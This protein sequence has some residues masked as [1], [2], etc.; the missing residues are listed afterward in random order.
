M[1]KILA[2]VLII[3]GLILMTRHS[4]PL[5]SFGTHS[6]VA[7]LFTAP[8]DRTNWLRIG[9]VAMGMV[10]LSLLIRGRR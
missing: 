5:D 2:V 4:T 7:R 1:P 9:G 3:A 6:D 10:G 8:G